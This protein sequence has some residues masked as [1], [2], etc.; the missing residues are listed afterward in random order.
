MA[1]NPAAPSPAPSKKAGEP[2]YIVLLLLTI[3]G[4]TV[5][6]LLVGVAFA[7]LLSFL[8]SIVGFALGLVL[9][10]LA[11]PLF[12]AL[13]AAAALKRKGRGLL[14]RRLVTGALIGATQLALFGAIMQWSSTTTGHLAMAGYEV[15]D[16]VGGVPVV[17][18]F[19]Y[20]QAERQHVPSRKPKPGTTP[21]PDGGVLVADGGV[22]SADGG[23]LVADGGVATTS[24]AGTA[25]VPSTT[26]RLPAP[27]KP[28][29]G[30]PLSARVAGNKPARVFAAGVQTAEGEALL[31]VG[32]VT[33]GGTFSTRI[34]DLSS[35]D[36]L[37]EATLIEA[38]EDGGAAAILGGAHLVVARPGRGAELVKS[39]E[40]GQ[41]LG[42][43]EVQGVRDVVIGPGGYGLAVVD[44]LA[45]G[46][47]VSQA[48]VT[49]PK[50]KQPATILRKSGD[51]VPGSA[52]D[53]T[54]AK[55]WAFKKS[56]GAG[57]VILTETYLEG[58]DD[59]ATRL[60]G[61]QWSVNPQRLLVVKLDTPKALVEITR[62]GLEPSGITGMELQIFGDAWVLPD[63]RA[64][65]DANFLD[66]GADGWLFLSKPNVGVLAL[67]PDKRASNDGPWTS[68]APRVRSLEANA[69]GTF[70]FRRDD[71]AAVLASIDNPA[72]ATAALLG[73]DALA[74]DG[75]KLGTVASVDVPLLARGNEWLIASVKLAGGAAPHDGIVLAS[76]ADV[77][78]GKAEVLLEVGQKIGDAA[79]NA[80]ARTVQ[81]IR[82]G[83][84]R[85][86]LLW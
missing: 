21:G 43:L 8:P 62:T 49:L 51:K 81:S 53:A 30:I 3:V 73:A 12:L 9:F 40:P 29:A 7:A 66:K 63:G 77:Q 6:A 46:G 19:L 39:L 38:A 65:F 68:A 56:S 76:R 35:F 15:L 4:A 79:P 54:V 48:L 23:V 61:D 26:A 57:S 42:D 24:D 58:G 13:R 37:G 84:G 82:F 72:S 17:S 14:L 1:E 50:D 78:N 16:V 55:S 60:S 41:K 27:P 85:D 28:K 80:K 10:G 86:E 52:T 71:G 59:L 44:L 20:A 69:D 74:S 47:E 18:D 31:V 2:R 34:V 45:G 64:L 33:T 25:T 32:T 83:K 22:A 70:V 11:L 67:A 36:K 5:G 75:K